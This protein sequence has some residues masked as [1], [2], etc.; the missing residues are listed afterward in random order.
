LRW[1][2]ADGDAKFVPINFDHK[3]RPRRQDWSGEFIEAGM[4]YFARR[5]LLDEGLFQNDK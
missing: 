2:R 4:F 5:L 3:K 1:Q